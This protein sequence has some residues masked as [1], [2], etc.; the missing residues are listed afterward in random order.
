MD[1]SLGKNQNDIKELLLT[2]KTPEIDFSVI[3]SGKK[4]SKAN[5]LYKIGKKEIVIH[6]KNFT[7]D[8]QLIYTAIHEYAHHLMWC[9]YCRSGKNPG[10]TN[11]FW[12][13]MYNLVDIAEQKGLYKKYSDEKIKIEIKTLVDEVKHIDREIAVLYKELGRQIEKINTQC[14]KFGVRF[15]DITIRECGLT[16]QTINMARSSYAL[17]VADIGQETQRAISS[18]KDL[19]KIQK[20]VDTVASGKTIYQAKQSIKKDLPIKISKGNSSQ[21]I[22]MLTRGI[23]FACG[24]INRGL[25]VAEVLKKAKINKSVAEICAVSETDILSLEDVFDE[26][27]L[28]SSKAN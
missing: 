18:E 11:E 6:N 10:H 3:F 20:I 1:E 23:C 24:Q 25:S 14:D 13:M 8:N 4:S 17:D 28:A 19:D 21:E 16:Q 9:K 26:L 7:N 27:K 15:E 12:N 22:K 5:G 2:L